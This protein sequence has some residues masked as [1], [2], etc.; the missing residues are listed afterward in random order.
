MASVT[1]VALL[2]ARDPSRLSLP[3]AVQRE[4]LAEDLVV[5]DVR[6]PTVRGSHSRVKSFVCIGEPSRPGVVEVRQR[7]LLE[8]LCRVPRRAEPAASDS[9]GPAR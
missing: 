7:A 6:R 5:G 1:T 8:R 3:A 2:V 9:Q 4:Q